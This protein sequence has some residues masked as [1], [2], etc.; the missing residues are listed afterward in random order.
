M[1]I[2]MNEEFWVWLKYLFL[3]QGELGVAA[4]G[5]I[6]YNWFCVADIIM[7][8]NN[9]RR[10]NSSGVWGGHMYF[11]NCTWRVVMI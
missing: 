2:M 3:S 6:G 1:T 4:T 5:L 8:I 11:A 7:F 9:N 10:K